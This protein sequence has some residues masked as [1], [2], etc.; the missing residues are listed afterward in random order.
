MAN[1]MSSAL[2]RS[3]IASSIAS[4]ST[5][6]TTISTASSTG[7]WV[8]RKRYT[9]PDAD[10]WVTVQSRF[11]FVENTG[12]TSHPDDDP[13]EVAQSANRRKMTI[14]AVMEKERL[15]RAA[16]RGRQL[17]NAAH[18]STSSSSVSSKPSIRVPYQVSGAVIHMNSTTSIVVKSDDATET[19]EKSRFAYSQTE[20]ATK[21][22][23]RRIR[24]IKKQDNT[25]SIHDAAKTERWVPE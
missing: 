5:T 7:R 3:S 14:D 1:K 6:D 13:T 10:Q 19:G 8:S 24:R 4:D 25:T 11:V 18:N 21:T 17:F 20:P 22:A 2:P 9:A 12:E 16:E 15:A 23:Q